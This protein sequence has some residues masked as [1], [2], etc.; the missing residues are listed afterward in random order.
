MSGGGANSTPQLWM[1]RL[2]AVDAVRTYEGTDSRLLCIRDDPR[3][4]ENP[5]WAPTYD[6]IAWIFHLIEESLHDG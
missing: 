3:T 1:L 6:Q 5:V 2:Q 4:G